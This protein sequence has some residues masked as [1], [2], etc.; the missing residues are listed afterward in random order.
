MISRGLYSGFFFGTRLVTETRLLSIST[1]YLDPGL[2]PGPG[3]YAGPGFYPKFS[4]I[5]AHTRCIERPLKPA[6]QLDNDID[7]AQLTNRYWLRPD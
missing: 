4:G 7:T 2:Y 3:I 1:N 6:T 5:C